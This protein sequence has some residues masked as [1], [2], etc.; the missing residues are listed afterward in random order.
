[1]LSLSRQFWVLIHR[2]AGLTIALFLVVAGATGVLLPFEKDLRTMV[3]RLMFDVQAPLPGTRPLDAIVLADLVERQ[4]GGKV[5]F[6]PLSVPADRVMSFSVGPADTNHQLPFDMVWSD[7]YTGTVKLKFRSGVLADGPQNIVP[8]IYRLHYSLAAGDWGIAA[9]GVAALVWT[10]DC[11]VGFYLTLPMRKKTEANRRA[12]KSWWARWKPAW[13]IRK[14]VRGHKLNF[15]LHRAGGLWLWPFLF[16]FAWTSVGFNLPNVHRPVMSILGASDD[17]PPTGTRDPLL[18][19]PIGLPAARELARS[20][21]QT[22]AEKRHFTIKSEGYIFYDQDHGLYRYSAHT[23]LD[24]ADDIAQTGLW[25]SAVDGKLSRFESPTDGT[26]AD[27]TMNWMY[28]LHMAHVFGLPYKI[29]VSLTGG[30]VTILSLTGVLIWMK[31]RSAK[32][33][34]GR[35]TASPA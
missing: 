32:R 17:M 2:W 10:V 12:G 3:E 13:K 30:M 27:K 22:E 9:F 34:R 4:T 25:L 19:P 20:L 24:P 28:M 11:F 7:P 5:L 1:M 26:M 16:V 14:G 8:F 23:S 29:L 33:Q 18:E 35:G 21:M 15:D 31:K 6:L